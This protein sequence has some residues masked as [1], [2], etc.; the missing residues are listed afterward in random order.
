MVYITP[1][2][3]RSK[4]L[5]VVR[6]FVIGLSGLGIALLVVGLWGRT[7][8]SSV[9]WPWIAAFAALALAFVL[10]LVGRLLRGPR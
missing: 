9:A 10:A 8:D 1:T 6:A 7:E 2:E 4:L 5:C 3:I